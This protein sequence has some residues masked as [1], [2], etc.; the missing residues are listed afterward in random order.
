[1]MFAGVGF[2]NSRIL[3][4]GS[5]GPDGHIPGG[6]ND[7]KNGNDHAHRGMCASKSSAHNQMPSERHANDRRHRRF[8]SIA[9]VFASVAEAN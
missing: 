8:T 5:V 6:H 2:I 3:S 9:E 7:N 1:M 4:F